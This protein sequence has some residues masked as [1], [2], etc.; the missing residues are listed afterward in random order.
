[1]NKYR[2]VDRGLRDGH[3]SYF[4]SSNQART[5]LEGNY[6]CWCYYNENLFCQEREGCENC[7]VKRRVD[8]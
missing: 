8:L 1:M 7:I 6:G 3:S 2:M 4:I 5:E